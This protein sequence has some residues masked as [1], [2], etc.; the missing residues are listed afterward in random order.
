MR[1]QAWA[2]LGQLCPA[3]CLSFP[4]VQNEAGWRIPKSHLLDTCTDA[5]GEFTRVLFTQP[6]KSALR[7]KLGHSHPS[8]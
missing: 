2:A 5:P 8:S 7:R 6:S 3:L 4:S 1:V